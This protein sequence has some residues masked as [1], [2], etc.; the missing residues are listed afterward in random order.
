VYLSGAVQLDFVDLRYSLYARNNANFPVAGTLWNTPW[1]WDKSILEDLAVEQQRAQEILPPYSPLTQLVEI[2][3][4]YGRA[5]D[6]EMYLNALSVN[7]SV[8]WHENSL[9]FAGYRTL[10]VG[11][12]ELASKWFSELENRS[13]KDFL[14]YSLANLR[15]GNLSTVEQSLA[16]AIQVDWPAPRIAD[17]R[18]L[19]WLLTRL[20]EERPLV[21]IGEDYL[22]DLTSSLGEHSI[23]GSYDSVSANEFCED[24]NATL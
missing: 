21:L 8:T 4:D 11:L 14:A 10:E 16:N 17:F 15:L 2:A 7:K 6:S 22:A 3:M 18:I 1:C 9:R 24:E 23:L 5:A 13:L 12:N 19:Q 20:S